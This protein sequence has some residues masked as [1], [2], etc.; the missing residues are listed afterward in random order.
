MRRILAALLLLLAAAPAQAQSWMHGS[1]FGEGQPGDKSSMYL[2]HL[3]PSGEF[4]GEYRTCRKGKAVD[5]TQQGWWEMKGDI[6]SITILQV[7]GFSD[8]RVDTYKILSHSQNAQKYLYLPGR[9]E[10]NARRVDAKFK[11]PPCDL[12]S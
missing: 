1:W 11:L 3:L 10:Y 9:F 5:S 4:R 2:D 7:N 6:L 8:P 12:V